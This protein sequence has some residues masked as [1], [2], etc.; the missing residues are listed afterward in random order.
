MPAGSAPSRRRPAS[1]GRA[2]HDAI[3][4][5]VHGFGARVDQLDE[6]VGRGAGAAG[7]NLVDPKTGVGG[8]GG[9]GGGS[10]IVHA[11]VASLCSSKRICTA[12]AW[13]ETVHGMPASSSKDARPLPGL[14]LRPGGPLRSGRP[15]GTGRP[16]WPGLA[17]MPCSP[18]GPGAPAAPAG[19]AAPRSPCGRAGLRRPSAR[20]G[21]RRSTTGGVPRP[22]TRPTP[23]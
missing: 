17:G 7:H 16:L 3:A 5:G 19:P 4:A 6:L 9:G 1:R 13:P 10:E 20:P 2:V 14:P 12:P 18:R 21:P 15:C 11:I 22:C 23:R 8:G